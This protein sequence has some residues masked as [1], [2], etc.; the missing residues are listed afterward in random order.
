MGKSEL[1]AGYRLAANEHP[2]SNTSAS[3]PIDLMEDKNN[4]IG[5]F[6]TCAIKETGVL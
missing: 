3:G 1:I 2:Y 6:L 4:L 5:A